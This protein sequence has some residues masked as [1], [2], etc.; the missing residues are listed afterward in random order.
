MI[1]IGVLCPSEIAFRRFMPALM[2]SEDFNYIGI[3]SANKEEWFGEPTEELVLAEKNKASKFMESY[4]G[5]VFANYQELLT[6]DEIDAV[7]IPLPPALHFKWAKAALENGKHVL[8]EKPFTTSLK[9]TE[10]LIEIARDKK[11][12]VHENYMFVY[13][14]QIDYINNLI[15]SK[16]VGDIRLIR[17]DFG[18]PFRGADDFRYKKALGGGALLD[19]G[20]YT[21]KLASLLL[22]KTAKVTT[23]HLNSKD[24][25]DVDIYG[26]ATLTN[27]D[28]LTAQVSFGMDNAYKCSIEIWGSTGTIYT[29]RILTAPDGFEPVVII[30][31]GNE[32]RTVKLPADD[33]FRKSIAYFG[34]CI[35]NAQE[36]VGHYN[37]IYR[38]SSLVEEF[39]RR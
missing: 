34:K 27:K 9:D 10:T 29:N 33:T 19:C 6:S 35:V 22:G 5:K 38:Q 30:R 28:G 11:L 39:D 31:Q 25:L 36:R 3:A 2:K 15:S 32:E 13:H 14:T 37:A 4:G 17:I 16:E 18:F 24:G 12:A 20:G 8:L 26:N 23:T 21:L 7:Y 1:N